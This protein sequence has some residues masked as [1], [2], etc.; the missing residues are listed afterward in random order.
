MIL[1]LMLLSLLDTPVE[2]GKTGLPV[3]S[4]VFREIDLAEGFD[5]MSQGNLMDREMSFQQPEGT[6][7]VGTR[8]LHGPADKGPRGNESVHGS[9]FYLQKHG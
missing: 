6:S 8:I 2:F 7:G 1:L 5:V 4:E 9:S 3:A